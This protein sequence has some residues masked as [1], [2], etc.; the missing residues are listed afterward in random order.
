[1]ECLLMASVSI[2]DG[3]KRLEALVPLLEKHQE[4]K[5]TQ[6]PVRSNYASKLGHPCERYLY[7]MRHD[8]DKATPRDWKGVGIR[9]NLVADWWKRYMQEKGFKVIHDQLPLSKELFNA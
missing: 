1:I 8:W 3:Q 5:N 6:Y 7:Y 2:S 4:F 9:G